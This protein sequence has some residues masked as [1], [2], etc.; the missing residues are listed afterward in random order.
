MCQIPDKMNFHKNDVRSVSLVLL[1]F[2]MIMGIA[3]SSDAFAQSTGMSINVN[4]DEGSSTISISG[5]TSTH[6]QDITIVVTAPNGNIVTVDQVSPDQNGK[7]MTEVQVG[8]LWKQDGLYLISA[9]QGDSSL[10][11]LAILVEISGGSA[12]AISASDSSLSFASSIASPTYTTAGLTLT[13]DAVEGAPNFGVSGHTDRTNED[14]TLR[15]SA[16]NGNVISVDQMAPEQNGDFST[17]INV[18]CPSWKQNGDYTITVQQG[19]NNL[20]KQSAD[21]EINDCV[22]IPEFGTIAALV[23]AVAIIS[24]V[25]VSARSR[26]SIIPKY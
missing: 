24:I 26:L 23:L 8:S 22:V 2:S 25:V 21:V 7:Y 15:V 5:Q 3:F 14:I 16:P 4:A 12:M 9:R 11:K 18:G 20:Y 1:A 13:I 10:Y 17:V 19:T 6:S